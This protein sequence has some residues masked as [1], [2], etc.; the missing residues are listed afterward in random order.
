MI[1]KY[2]EQQVNRGKEFQNSNKTWNGYATLDYAK[3]IKKYI[4]K[5]DSKSLLDYGCGKGLHYIVNR[6]YENQETT[7][8]KYIGVSEIFKYDPCIDLFSKLPAPDQKF[9]ATISIQALG[10]IPDEDIPWVVKL[11][12]NHTKQF[13]FI[14]MVDPLKPIKQKKA[15]ILDPDAFKVTRSVDWYLEQFKGWEGSELVFYWL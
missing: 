1:S 7:F 2:Y 3:E 9:D 8:D 12:M 13:C 15:N 6:E 5:Y 14:G 11:L 4:V 10:Y